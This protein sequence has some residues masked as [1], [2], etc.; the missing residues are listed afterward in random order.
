MAARTAAR[1]RARVEK[2]ARDWLA[3]CRLRS[4]NSAA[5]K[6]GPTA[7]GALPLPPLVLPRGPLITKHLITPFGPDIAAPAA[8]P[9]A[10]PCTMGGFKLPPIEDNTEGWGP[11]TAPP[12]FENVPFMPFGKGDRLG[13]IADFGM[14]AGR[15]QYQSELA[16][17]A[18]RIARPIAQGGIDARAPRRRPRRAPPAR[19]CP[20]PTLIITSPLCPSLAPPQTDTSASPPQAPRS[21]TLRRPRRTRPSSWWTTSR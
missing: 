14:P 19:S 4:L 8:P 20:R 13:R 11:T 1:Q 10:A 7:G 15:A 5:C 18:P 9:P 6:K 16:R 12:Q 17:C 21:S 2:S 3:R